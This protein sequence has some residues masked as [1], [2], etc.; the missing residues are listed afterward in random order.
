[1]YANRRKYWHRSLSLETTSERFKIYGDGECQ[2]KNFMVLNGFEHIAYPC[3]TEEEAIET[4][5]SLRKVAFALFS[6]QD[7]YHLVF[8]DSKE[9]GKQQKVQKPQWHSAEKILARIMP[10]NFLGAF[11]ATPND[12]LKILGVYG[13]QFGNYVPQKLRQK[14]MN[15]T[16]E[17]YVDLAQILDVMPS[18]IF[19]A[20]QKNARLAIAFG[21]RGRGGASGGIAHFEPFYEVMNFTKRKG[22]GCLAHEWGHAFDNF[23]Y[24]SM[25]GETAKAKGNP[26]IIGIPYQSFE[27]FNWNFLSDEL[28]IIRDIFNARHCEY[29]SISYAFA[30]KYRGGEKYWCSKCE[31]FARAFEAY[32]LDKMAEKGYVSDAL[33]YKHEAYPYPEGE[34]RKKIN[35]ALDGIFSKLKEHG[36]F[37]P[38]DETLV[39]PEE[40]K[41][42]KILL[43]TDDYAVNLQVENG[44]QISFVAMS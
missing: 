17:A 29:R 12:F 32:V 28:T 16:F 26:F 18:D 34:E 10:K 1:K 15:L 42:K 39:V 44:G 21:A 5:N 14:Q 37:H 24:K 20:G 23:L 2:Y 13:C 22:Y 36:V 7:D 9:T 40:T 25:T 11:N 43:G 8:K 30:Q 38:F 27:R 35:M 31:M 41:R 4:V 19:F 6:V 3:E 33:V